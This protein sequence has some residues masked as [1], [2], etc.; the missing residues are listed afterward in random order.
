[1][2]L[3]LEWNKNNNYKGLDKF[4][5]KKFVLM[6]YNWSYCPQANWLGY[7]YK[8]QMVVH[9]TKKKDNSQIIVDKYKF[10]E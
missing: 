1:M 3:P 2:I 6:K 10:K 7:G 8:E 4:E 9:N 5:R